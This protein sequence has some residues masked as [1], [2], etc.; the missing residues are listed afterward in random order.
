[1]PAP[2][3]RCV[4]NNNAGAGVAQFL[5]AAIDIRCEAG[6]R[7]LAVTAQVYRQIWE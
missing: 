4:R 7:C 5:L 3:G 2:R 1:V 6:F